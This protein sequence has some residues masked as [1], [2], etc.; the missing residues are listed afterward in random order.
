MQNGIEDKK[1]LND[2][3]QKNRNG[4]FFTMGAIIF[5]LVVVIVFLAAQ[6]YFLK[7][8]ISEVEELSRRFLELNLDGEYTDDSAENGGNSE[9]GEVD[10]LLEELIAFAKKKNGYP[11]GRA[12]SLAGHIYA[13]RKDWP[14][15]QEAYTNSA[16]K[17]V[18]TFLAP[19]SFFNAAAA[20]EEQGSWEEAIK[21]Y[22]SSVSQRAEFAAAPRAQFAV[23]RLNEKTGNIPAAIA[24]YRVILSRWPSITVWANLA[25]SRL[26]VLNDAPPQQESIEE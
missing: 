12:W 16:N 25:Q 8:A 18:K 11:S 3:V 21:L 10:A 17:A 2:F 7:K 15:A 19:A 22:E 20:A 14:E 13:K 26:A 9:S 1:T 24:A 6:D 4:I 5:L 23:G